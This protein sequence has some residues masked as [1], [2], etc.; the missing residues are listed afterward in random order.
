MQTTAA[1]SGEGES[2]QVQLAALE[3]LLEEAR[4]LIQAQEH[5]VESLRAAGQD[6]KRAEGLLDA[7]R[8]SARIAAERKCELE[9]EL[10]RR[11]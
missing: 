4:K 8:E 5:E 6:T 11:S 7:Y 10:A 1:Q 9:R 3:S 2:A